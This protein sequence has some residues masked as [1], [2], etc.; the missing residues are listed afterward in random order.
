M[1]GDKLLTGGLYYNKKIKIKQIIMI[2]TY[3]K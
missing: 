2:K 1:H 3:I